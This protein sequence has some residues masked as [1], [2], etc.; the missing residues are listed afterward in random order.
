MKFVLLNIALL[1]SFKAYA[2]NPLPT[3][4]FV[5][6]KRYMGK[7][8]VITSLPKFYTKR[9]IAQVADY[10]I[11]GSGKVFLKNTCIKKGDRTSSMEGEGTVI[12]KTTNAEIEVDFDNFFTKL[13]GLKGDYTIIKLDPEYGYVMVGNKKRTSLWIMSR[14]REMPKDLLEE[15]IKFAKKVGFKVEGLKK[16]KYFKD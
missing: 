3:A 14:D 5:D 16:S 11:L 10:K 6:L 4:K 12:N 2:L 15:Y 8:F 7:W 9:C 13:F 1:I